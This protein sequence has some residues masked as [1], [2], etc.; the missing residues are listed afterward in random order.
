MNRD[1]ETNRLG[2][3]LRARRD[4]VT[5]EQSGVAAGLH[6]RVLG[7]RREEVAMLAGISADY[8][9]RWS[10]GV[11]RTPRSRCLRR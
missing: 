9:L 2:A 11:T 3:Y 1:E 4:L 10:V 8:Y 7:L 5:P 6:R